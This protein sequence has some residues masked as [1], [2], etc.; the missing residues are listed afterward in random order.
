MS[1]FS[2][3]GSGFGQTNPFG[4]MKQTGFGQTQSPIFGNN[5]ASSSTQ[6]SVFGQSS[7]SKQT[8]V[9]GQGLSSGFAKIQHRQASVF[10]QSGSGFG[11]NQG[12]TQTSSIFGQPPASVFGQS[13][14]SGFSQT[15]S[16]AF[17]QS[18]STSFGSTS[19]G[20]TAQS[21]VFGQSQSSGFGPTSS[22]TTA[23]SNVFGQSQSTGFGSTSSS[24]T[25]QS[26]VFGQSQSTGFG[27]ASSSTTA[28]SNVFM[29]TSGAASA[30]SQTNPFATSSVFGQSGNQGASQN[31]SGG[32]SSTQ[33]AMSG[34]GF[35]STGGI[36]G[37]KDS[38]MTTSSTFQTSAFGT[39]TT[40]TSSAFG[41][42]SS[43]F[44]G[45][46]SKSVFGA[47][48]GASDG[49]GF[50]VAMTTCKS[51]PVFGGPPATTSIF[52]SAQSSVFGAKKESPAVFGGTSDSGSV[53]GGAKKDSSTVFRGSTS[54]SGSSTFG[55]VR[56]GSGSLFGAKT[57][58]KPASENLFKSVSASTGGGLFGKKS[59]L[60]STDIVTEQSPMSQTSSTGQGTQSKSISS[61]FGSSKVFREQ[62]GSTGES[63]FMGGKSGAQTGPDDETGESKPGVK[64]LFGKTTFKST[65]SGFR[66]SDK[67][68]SEGGLFGAP[69]KKE[70]GR[71]LFGGEEQEA[72]KEEDRS[73]KRSIRRDDESTSKRGRSLFS[74]A[75]AGAVAGSGMR[76]DRTGPRPSVTDRTEPRPSTSRS[77]DP[78]VEPGQEGSRES[79]STT[80]MR[81]RR[82]PSVA[83]DVT[84]KI[85]I[86][87][88][89][90]PTKFNKGSI[91][92][93]HFSKYGSVS[94]VFP[95]V[96]KKSATIHFNDHK[97]AAEAK[98]RG[99]V[100][101]KGIPPLQIFWST[102]SPGITRSMSV[103]SAASP[104]GLETS[105]TVNSD[106]TS[107]GKIVKKSKWDEDDVDDELSSMSGTQDVKSYHQEGDTTARLI[108]SKLSESDFPK[109]SPTKTTSDTVS[110]SSL[111][112]A[113]AKNVHD[114][115]KILDLRDK[116]IREGR[117][118]QFNLATARAFVGTCMDMCPEKERYDREE[119]RRLGMFEYVPG[120][121]NIPGQNPRADH[122]RVVKEYSRSSAD[123]DEPLPHELRPI[124]VLVRTMDYLLTEI[125]DKGTDGRWMDW[126]G[127]LW[128]R[129]RGIRKDITQQ[130]LMNREAVELLEKCA[131]F[132]IFCSER[133]CEEDMH[134]F[135][136]KINNENLTKCL[137]T[138]K[139]MY[140]D[141]DVKHQVFC[142]SEAEFRA[143]IV[144]M[145]LNEGDTLREVQTLRSEV[146]TSTEIKFVIKVYTALN[147]NNY[148]RFFRLM[149]ESSFLNACIIH[150]YFTQVRSRALQTMIK[151]FGGKKSQ[152]PLTEL[153]RILSFD[154][155]N[156]AAAFCQF[157]GLKVAD[158]AVVLDKSSLVIPE[159][160]YAPRR[161]IT[162]IESKR[163]VPVGEVISGS[164]LPPLHLPEPHCS[165]DSNGRFRLGPE[166]LKYEGTKGKK[167]VEKS[168][169][170]KKPTPVSTV[171]QPPV[172]PSTPVQSP[173]A[174]TSTQEESAA[175]TPET[176]QFSNEAVKMIAREL[177]WEVIDEFVREISTGYVRAVQLYLDAGKKTV[178]E[179]VVIGTAT[180]IRQV[181]QE[182]F[183]EE[184]ELQQQV[185]AAELKDRQCRVSEDLCQDLVEDVTKQE[186]Q[187][188]AVAQVREVQAQLKQEREERCTAVVADDVVENTL[189]KLI[190]EISEEVHR[191]D[192][193]QRLAKLEAIEKQVKTMRSCRF[194]Q[195]WKR[196]HAKRVK[197]KRAMLA[198][199]C[200]P[201]TQDVHSQLQTLLPDRSSDRVV[202]GRMYVN[203]QAMVAIETPMDIEKRDKLF[204]ARHSLIM[205]THRLLKEKAWQPFDI[206]A[207]A[208][209][210]FEKSFLKQRD[211]ETLIAETAPEITWKL[212]V[213]LPDAAAASTA[214][215]DVAELVNKWLCAK[216]QRG[217]V[218]DEPHLKY[219]GEVLSLYHS[220]VKGQGRQPLQVGVCV[221]TVV[222]TLNKKEV[223]K[224]EEKRLLLGS[225][226]ILF[227]LPPVED[228]QSYW[229][230]AT[231]RLAGVL[232]AKPKSPA[233]PLV[234]VVPESANGSFS[235]SELVQRLEM[236]SFQDDGLVSEVNKL[237]LHASVAELE[238]DLPQAAD[239]L[240]ES[241][242]WLVDH[243]AELPT[244]LKAR[245]DD[246]VEELLLQ[247]YFTPVLRKKPPGEPQQGET[248]SLTAPGSTASTL[249]ENCA[250][251]TLIT[252][253]NCVVE[254][255]AEVASSAHL[256]AISCPIPEFVWCFQKI[257]LPASHWNT[258]DHLSHLY[259]EISMLQLPR[260]RYYNYHSNSW[261]QVCSDVWAFVQDVV[262]Q[263]KG[264]NTVHLAT[265]IKSLLQKVWEE[266]NDVCYL[267]EGEDRCEPTYVNMPWTD[268]ID[269]CINYRISCLPI[270]DKHSQENPPRELVVYYSEEEFNDFAVPE[271]WKEAMFDSNID[272]RT[273]METV[274]KAVEKKHE[275]CAAKS[276]EE[277]IPVLMTMTEGY[278]E[279]DSLRSLTSKCSSLM[280]SIAA[281]KEKDRK[282][283]KYLESL[284]LDG[285]MEM[286]GGMDGNFLPVASGGAC[287]WY[288]VSGVKTHQV[289][290][291]NGVKDPE[292]DQ[293]VEAEH[294]E[295][296]ADMTIGGRMNSLKDKV[297]AFRQESQ[298]FEKRL[299]FLLNS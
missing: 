109:P 244:L 71:S 102:H 10:G 35:G 181:C 156:E 190:H 159:S 70:P 239:R 170:E 132:H 11:Q 172:S 86:I 49:S 276:E 5:Q 269:A 66:E 40:P 155:V 201:S 179:I 248:H 63:P 216:L 95:N 169:P 44:G 221:R 103:T 64:T 55:S 120:S 73:R 146:R 171:L 50:G 222:G 295:E 259:E 254:H 252:L 46:S 124:P 65:A 210:E 211:P 107:E 191:V 33:G 15:Q 98:A 260:F 285:N 229:K 114:M 158:G 298:L 157:Y 182:V 14:S 112:T 118:K 4:Q 125:A 24:T 128:D 270:I 236:D 166:L 225:A 224:M 195:I 126:Y 97:S 267:T 188:L 122:S 27:S 278:Y 253:Y 272:C 189:E 243:M 280:T 48:T 117:T 192:V 268:V 299:E 264:K 87:C 218:P 262:K 226:G 174:V 22:N 281:E 93:K 251:N 288:P 202:N 250:P 177:F 258:S 80:T 241:L 89:N 263:N 275:K 255:L 8:S 196:E 144:L 163:M 184:T 78:D 203:Q 54:T 176:T 92:R 116:F 140:H 162:L 297:D 271:S 283:E 246:Y 220:K 143:F 147:S 7:T 104:E 194:L 235:V 100:L 19:S 245:V 265:R 284:L 214:D 215:T 249:C 101:A 25:A 20:T 1:G 32:F 165:F 178:E 28:Q 142:P 12:Q 130:Q 256:T 183:A 99:R 113:V 242:V 17:G 154:N 175:A 287:D 223:Q 234:I 292:P 238:S 294:C 151:A 161:A 91:L 227:V 108:T 193:V 131:R 21:N 115:I 45:S 84:S 31:T 205:L 167:Q 136:E 141:L 61:V 38:K 219:R 135:D 88:K 173:L 274:E 68:R 51:S 23:Q 13:Q 85:A 41:G 67:A 230:Q 282:F 62:A 160:A 79:R 81:L 30:M 72:A 111:R 36:F 180:L 76:S 42:K 83:E 199:P 127:F 206:P 185:L 52:S 208:G 150:R 58:S 96:N 69:V 59:D 257:E 289:L 266:F 186:A 74:S 6:S 200:A 293:D 207:V 105:P 233:L 134:V 29:A 148:V 138:L 16:N 286:D 212:T 43:V 94:K 168:S 56:K 231:S 3:S 75:M 228:N 123:Q 237:S 149:K 145:N 209:K 277:E 18:Q 197:L 164:A 273:V 247:E 57:S 82:L 198:F 261:E 204:I 106:N 217:D 9:F 139:E 77:G 296:D 232:H 133:L 129:T 47:T 291:K 2:Q 34:S 153:V 90:V 119:K 121:E 26:N 137:Q 187:S 240:S 152:F 213:S 53:F 279:S 290:G 37:A 110:L 60:P 39:S